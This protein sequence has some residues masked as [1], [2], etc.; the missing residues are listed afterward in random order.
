MRDE[1]IVEYKGNYVYAAMYGKNNYD[2][3]LELW[4]RIMAACKQYNCFNILGENFTT[5]ELS[6]M[7]AYDHLRILEEVGLTLQYRVAWVDQA[8][9]TARGLEFVETVVVKNRGLAN[10]R[11]FSNIEDA[12]RWLLGE[13]NK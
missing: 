5:E 1:M 10:G 6:T 11:L 7:D 9:P 4:R 8:T 13:E 12:K 3:S 2:L